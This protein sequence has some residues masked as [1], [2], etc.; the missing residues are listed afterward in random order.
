[1]ALDNLI[2]TNHVHT[3]LEG[4]HNQKYEITEKGMN[5][6]DFFTANIPIYIREPIEQS[7]KE[8]FIEERRRNAI[9]SN[10]APV[11]KGEYSTEC[12]LYDDDN[13]QLLSLSLYVGSREEAERMSELF[14][15]HSDIVYAKILEAFSEK[16]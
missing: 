15:E 9:R 6:G 11:R 13:T 8:L 16:Y 2:T 1:M 14:R 7:I 12:Q 10:I 3:F 4:E 5:A